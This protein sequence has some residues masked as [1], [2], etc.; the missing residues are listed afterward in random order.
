[1]TGLYKIK[2]V[3]DTSHTGSL[4]S[5]LNKENLTPTEPELLTDKISRVQLQEDS[6]QTELKQTTLFM[7][8]MPKTP[9]FLG[10][11]NFI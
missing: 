1:M 11:Y 8:E 5:V 4:K 6:Q 9:E 3:N 2:P 7:N 10:K